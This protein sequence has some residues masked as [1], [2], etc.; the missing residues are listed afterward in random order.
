MLRRVGARFGW[1]LLQGTRT[2]DTAAAPSVKVT[3]GIVGLEVV[4]HAQSVLR[5]KCQEVLKAVQIIPADTEYRRC[6]EST[7]NY[8]R[9][10]GES[11]RYCHPA[12]QDIGNA[13]YTRCSQDKKY[14]KRRHRWR[15]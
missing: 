15:G 2:I 12:G 8:R 5:E 3:T 11:E 4:P 13:S 7:M 1:Q 6:V 9:V 14:P 10:P